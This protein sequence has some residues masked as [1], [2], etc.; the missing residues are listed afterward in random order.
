MRAL[1]DKASSSLLLFLLY[2]VV[3]RHTR[4]GSSSPNLRRVLPYLIAIFDSV[5]QLSACH[6]PIYLS[7]EAFTQPIMF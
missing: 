1:A 2:A 7:D 4:A 3:C 5:L 6:H